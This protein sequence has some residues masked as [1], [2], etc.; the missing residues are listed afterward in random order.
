MSAGAPP[1]PGASPPSPAPSPPASPPLVRRR[2][3]RGRLLAILGVIVVVVIV[4]GAGATTH[5]FGLRPA[6]TSTAACPTGVTLDGAGA[7]FVNTLVTQWAYVYNSVTS[8]KVSYDSS[9]AGVGI[10]DF[11]EKET[12]FA[13]TDEPVTYQEVATFPGTTLTLPVTGGAVTIVYYLPGYTHHLE[14]NASTLVGI[15]SG[16]ITNW[17]SPLLNESGL[18]PGLPDQTI[19][20]VVRSDA[21]GT[22]YVLTN[23]LS[24]DNSTWAKDVGTS[25]QPTWPTVPNDTERPEKGNSGLA[26]FVNET[27]YSIGYVDLA[28]AESHTNLG[29]AAVENPKLAYIVPTVPD[30]QSA[31]DDLAGQPI[32]PATGNWSAVSWV[33]APGAGDYPLATLTYF[34]VLENPALGYDPSL[35]NTTVLVQWLNWVLTDGQSYSS[36]LLYVNPPSAILTQDQQAVSSVNYNGASIPT[37]ST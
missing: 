7:S 31:I 3:D 20:P 11:G 18:N 19:I 23:Y 35:A 6:A 17:D 10:A 21:A 32:P 14:L 28:D 37:C 15:Y 36:S 25:I 4:L 12:Q 16:T 30:T 8:N 24:D 27:Q 26:S 34:L 2:S 1:P 9:S 33:N 5:W 22:T 13:A 29:I